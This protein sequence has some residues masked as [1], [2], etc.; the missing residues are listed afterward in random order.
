MKQVIIDIFNNGDI[1]RTEISDDEIIIIKDISL[2]E[3]AKSKFI[4]EDVIII[5]L[6]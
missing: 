2:F 3:D 1:E 5:L 4:I 6:N